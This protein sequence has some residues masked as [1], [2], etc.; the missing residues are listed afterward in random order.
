MPGMG[1][2]GLDHVQVA[3][4]PGCER[5]A[6]SFYGELL[7]LSELPKP[8]GLQSGGGVWFAAG[9]QELHVGVV[10]DFAPA[11]KAHPGL[12]VDSD[13]ALDAVAGALTAAG[14]AVEWD[15]RIPGR[16][17]FFTSDPWGNRVELLGP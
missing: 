5:E 7:G 15:E 12:R 17:R 10:E 1:V 2:D 16:R 4:P 11:R 13:G 6:R 8:A 9:A 3:A 14:A